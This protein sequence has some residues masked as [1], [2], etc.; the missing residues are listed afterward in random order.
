MAEVIGLAASVIAVAQTAWTVAKGLHDLADEV[1]SAGEAVRVF[2]NDFKFFV[3]NLKE[4]GELLDGLPSTSRKAESATQDLLEVATDQVVQPFQRLLRDL[5]P[6]LERWH[7][8]PSRMKQLGVRLQWAFSYKSK[9]LFFHG[10]LNALKSNVSLLLQT[11]ALKGQHQPHI[12][13]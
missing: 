7:E 6:L 11:M 13:L 9:V 10:A 4:L 3:E 12:Y 2:A 5:Q 8:S 1:G